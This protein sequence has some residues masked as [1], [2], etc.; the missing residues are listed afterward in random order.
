MP[1]R[2]PKTA[3]HPVPDYGIADSFV[4][5]KPEPATV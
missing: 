3:F 1:D 4:Y 2:F 5:Q